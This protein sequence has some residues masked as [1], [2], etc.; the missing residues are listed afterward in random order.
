M[1]PSMCLGCRNRSST[2]SFEILPLGRM[3]FADAVPTWNCPRRIT[4]IISGSGGD[5]PM[6]ARMA[7]DL[8]IQAESDL[9]FI[10]GGRTAPACVGVSVVDMATGA[11]AHPAKRESLIACGI[12]GMGARVGVSVSDVMADWLTVPSLHHE[13]G[14]SPSRVGLSHPSIAPCGVFT[15]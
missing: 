5:G 10:T 11:T 8:L 1:S 14:K 4:C 13:G 7:C 9:C 6:A 2:R 15:T 3:G 12:T